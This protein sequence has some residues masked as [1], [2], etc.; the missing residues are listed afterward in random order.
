ML[1]L[2]SVL[3]CGLFPSLWELPQQLPRFGFFI[4]HRAQPGPSPPFPAVP[5]MVVTVVGAQHVKPSVRACLMGGTQEMTSATD[6]LQIEILHLNECL[7]W[8]P[9]LGSTFF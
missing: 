9:S 7:H 5:Q 2:L 1:L 3:V 8:V 6:L 4:F